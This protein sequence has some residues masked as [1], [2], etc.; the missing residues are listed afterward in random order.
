MKR[1]KPPAERMPRASVLR[2]ADNHQTFVS[3]STKQTGRRC[4]NSQ[5]NTVAPVGENGRQLGRSINLSAC[6]SVLLDQTTSYVVCT[7]ICILHAQA[8]NSHMLSIPAYAYQRTPTFYY[9][10]PTP[11][12]ISTVRSRQSGS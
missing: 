6:P 1:T 9:Y 3:M 7:N 5:Q 10:V 11:I 2:V 12:N 4:G 8:V